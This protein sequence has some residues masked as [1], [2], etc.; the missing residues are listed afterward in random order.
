MKAYVKATTLL[1]VLGLSILTLCLTGH[2]GTSETAESFDTVARRAF[3]AVRD[4]DWNALKPD[5]APKIVFA[6]YMRG[7]TQEL[8]KEQVRLMFPAVLFTEKDLK[9]P[10][11][12]RYHVV[13]RL[14][15]TAKPLGVRDAVAFK[16]FSKYVRESWTTERSSNKFA[17]DNTAVE[18]RELVGPAVSGTYAS[19]V[20][21]RIELERNSGRWRVNRLVLMLH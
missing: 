9:S 17:Q 16:T 7:Y 6:Q 20:N 2:K 5:A 4:G 12:S 1:A 21:W 11:V 3:S 13:Y 18:V 14:V 8:S 19:N 15:D 10:D